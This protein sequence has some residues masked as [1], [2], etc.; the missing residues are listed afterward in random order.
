ME[1]ASDRDLA[2][3]RRISRVRV[4]ECGTATQI[5]AT[6]AQPDRTSVLP[7]RM[8]AH[9]DT[10][11]VG[12]DR[13]GRRHDPERRGPFLVGTVFGQAAVLAWGTCERRSTYLLRPRS[14]FRKSRALNGSMRVPPGSPPSIV[15]RGAPATDAH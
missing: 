4:A 9:A 5:A 10:A 11:D 2:D 14:R 6:P 1:C 15:H 12:M 8:P 3:F 7:R 13:S